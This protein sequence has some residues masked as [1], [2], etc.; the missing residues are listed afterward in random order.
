MGS[1]TTAKMALLND[2]KFV[3]FELSEKYHKI[4]EQRIY[5]ILVDLNSKLW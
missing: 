2:R 3:G 1:G 4:A 5:S